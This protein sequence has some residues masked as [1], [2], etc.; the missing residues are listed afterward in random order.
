MNFEQPTKPIRPA[1]LPIKKKKRVRKPGTRGPLG[2]RIAITLFIAAAIL[3][4]LKLWACFNVTDPHLNYMDVTRNGEALVLLDGETARFHPGDRLRIVDIFTN[5]CFN[6]GVRIVSGGIDANSLIYDDVLLSDLL[7]EK[8]IYSSYT[9]RLEVK[10]YNKSMGYID[11][12]VEPLVEDWLD[13]AEKTVESDKRIEVFKQAQELFPEE[14]RIKDRLV[15]EY[16]SLKKW[17]DAAKILEGIVKEKPEQETYRTLLDVYTNMSN[18]TG[19]ISVLRRMIELTPDNADLKLKMADALTGAGRTTEAI[20]GYEELLDSIKGQ[21]LLPVYNNLGYLYA[22][23]GDNEKAISFFLKALELNEGDVN[24]YHNLSLLYEKMGQKEKANQYL[25]KAVELKPDSTDDRL[26]LAENL[27]ETGK[28]KE[29]EKSV[30][31]FI[32]DNPGSMDAWLLM[33]SIAEK[34]GD[35]TLLKTTYEKILTINPQNDTVIY[36]LGVMEYDAGNLD[37]ALPY[38]EKYIKSSPDDAMAQSFLYE[39]YKA[40]KKDD[41]AYRSASAI[42]KLKPDETECWQ[43]IFEYLSRKE[44]YKE[45]ASIMEEGIKTSPRD[46]TLRKYLVAAYLKTGKENQAIIQMKAFLEQKPRDT[47]MFLQLAKLYE[48]QSKPQEALDAYKKILDINPD[49]EEAEEAYLRLRLKT[50]PK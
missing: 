35:K 4:V 26:R 32:R 13:K 33:M 25:V 41:M 50:I 46:M 1:P 45:M 29:A 38:F 28:I 7:P 47:D 24:I 31:E 8:D 37:K 36:N 3:G 11:L 14:R 21:D 6:R 9:F 12:V 16:I 18:D 30:K 34:N 2:A 23:T 19:V 15:K 10:R 22:E 40:Q 5:I 44:K 20:S 43:Y 17:E 39:I 48:K 42:I 27:F 49:N